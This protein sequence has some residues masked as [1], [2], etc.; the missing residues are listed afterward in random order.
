MKLLPP[1]SDTILPTRTLPPEVVLPATLDPIP[2]Q[3]RALIDSRWASSTQRNYN[4]GWRRFQS[5]CSQ[6]G[7]NPLPA[8]PETVCRFLAEQSELFSHLSRIQAAYGAIR[9]VHVR[10]GI[11]SPTGDERVRLVFSAIKKKLGT[12]SEG[13]SPLKGDTLAKVVKAID[14]STLHGKRDAALVLTGFWLALRKDSLRLLRA[15]LV[16]P[17]EYGYSL[18][19]DRSKTDQLKKGVWMSLERRAKSAL[20]PVR[21]LKEWLEASGLKSGPIFVKV[22]HSGTFWPEALSGRSISLLIKRLV[23]NAGLDPTNFSG[24]SMRV[25]FVTEAMEQGSTTA[26]VRDVTGHK[27]DTM[28]LRYWRHWGAPSRQSPSKRMRMPGEGSRGESEGEE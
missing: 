7:F 1:Q 18:F 16:K 6:N 3:I 10:Q 8:S 15:E 28:L 21:A 23:T 13:K 19:L 26:Q 27:S 9:W 20:C 24:H 14:R 2:A 22:N 17:T 25:G 5:W 11:P 12:R 4:V